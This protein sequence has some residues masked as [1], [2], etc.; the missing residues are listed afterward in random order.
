MADTAWTDQTAFEFAARKVIEQGRQSI[1]SGQGGCLYRGPG[2]LKCH[3][4]W[5]IPDDWYNSFGDPEV[6]EGRTSFDLVE[7]VPEF[8]G[9][10]AEFLSYCQKAHDDADEY[11]DDADAGFVA[12]YSRR[13]RKVAARFGLDASFLN[14]LVPA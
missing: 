1:Y 9:L 5:L 4:G 8:S 13:L 10:N 14:E 12:Q 11:A 2:G 7:I 3:I 6:V